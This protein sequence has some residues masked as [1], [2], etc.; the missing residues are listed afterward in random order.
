MIGS[1]RRPSMAEVPEKME[2]LPIRTTMS[3]EM[4]LGI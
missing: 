2:W 4:I 3:W 1:G